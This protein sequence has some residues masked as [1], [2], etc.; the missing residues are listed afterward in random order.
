MSNGVN[1]SAC[2]LITETQNWP[3]VPQELEPTNCCE[4]NETPW[5]H[6]DQGGGQWGPILFH[7]KQLNICAL[8]FSFLYDFFSHSLVFAFTQMYF[9]FNIILPLFYFLFFRSKWCMWVR[10]MFNVSILHPCISREELTSAPWGGWTAVPHLFVFRLIGTAICLL[11][12]W[13]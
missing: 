6:C 11:S 10:K 4:A 7:L 9:W 13:W 3:R 5:W 2:A 1:S 8:K 12:C